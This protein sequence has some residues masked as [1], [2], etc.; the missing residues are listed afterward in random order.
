GERGP[1]IRRERVQLR[2]PRRGPDRK[3]DRAGLHGRRVLHATDA[4]TRSRRGNRADPPLPP[5]PALPA[6]LM[7]AQ[8]DGPHFVTQPLPT[9]QLTRHAPGTAWQRS[10]FAAHAFASSEAQ[11][12]VAGTQLSVHVVAQ[13]VPT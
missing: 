1:L 13:P 3:N 10:P 8:V 7:G 9:V 2:L 6:Q 12:T 11:S 4:S 5:L